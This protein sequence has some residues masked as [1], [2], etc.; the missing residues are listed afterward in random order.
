MEF[1][2]LRRTFLFQDLGIKTQRPG[3][4]AEAGN[5]TKPSCCGQDW[6][7]CPLQECAGLPVISIER[8][9]ELVRIVKT[10]VFSGVRDDHA[11]LGYKY[12]GLPFLRKEARAG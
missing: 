4:L 3:K 6:A 9:A 7:V 12:G 10:N 1:H 8:G 5:S 11:H 2:M